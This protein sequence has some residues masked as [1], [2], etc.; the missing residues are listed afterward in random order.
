[1]RWIVE[2]T[3]NQEKTAN[4]SS[5]HKTQYTSQHI[6]ILWIVNEIE[7]KRVNMWLVSW[8]YIHIYI[9]THIR[10]Y[11]PK[12]RVKSFEWRQR[13]ET[14]QNLS[15]NFRVNITSVTCSILIIVLHFK[16]TSGLRLRCFLEIY[17]Q[18][19]GTKC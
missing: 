12:I 2:I 18:L 13:L 4:L 5:S 17:A 1:M 7:R 19:Q 16:G 6:Y 9:Y 8:I 11:A 14:N 3:E 10:I 15:S